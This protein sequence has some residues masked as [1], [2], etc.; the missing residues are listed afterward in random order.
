MDKDVTFTGGRGR[1]RGT[2]HKP[3][4]PGPFQAMIVLHS[5]SGGSR[6]DPFYDHLKEQIP[7]RDTAVLVYD[8][9]GTGESEGNFSTA[10][11]ED[12][13][14]DGAAAFNYLRERPDIDADRIGLYGISQGGWIAPI[15]AIKEPAAA[16]LVIISGCAV[17]P[18]AQMDYG[19]RYTLA[20]AG[21]PKEIQ[22]QALNLRHQVNEYYRGN[23]ERDAL[24]EEVRKAEGESWFEYAYIPG[25]DR[26]PE[27][28]T[29]SKWYYEMDYDPLPIWQNLKQ[30][31]LFLFGDR[32]RW[33]PVPESHSRYQDATAHMDEVKFV[34]LSGVDHL[35]HHADGRT[36]GQLS[37]KYLEALLDWIKAR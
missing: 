12:L 18:A 19:A 8:R 17:P 5:A 15:V 35:M 1:L 11:F 29:Q 36:E 33:V 23:L 7:I 3:D 4:G 2:L 13:A 31:A 14:I 9:R 30:P 37:V 6:L 27:D 28:V 32:D 34:T 22:Q 10:D 16:F 25:S 24:L 20:E 21:F 26:L